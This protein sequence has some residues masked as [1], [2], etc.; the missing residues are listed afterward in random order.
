MKIKLVE[1]HTTAA[2]TV[3]TES[4]TGIAWS[5]SD[6]GQISE[7]LF[8]CGE[9]GKIRKW[10][11]CGGPVSLVSELDSPCTCL[12][13]VPPIQAQSDTMAVGCADGSIRFFN[14][15]GRL[16][17]KF[18]AHEGALISVQWSHDATT[19][20]STGE[21]CFLKTWSRSGMQRSTLIQMPREINCFTWSPDCQ[22]VL[23]GS[24]SKIMLKP[25]QA[26]QKQF[27]WKA[28][29]GCVL[30]LDWCS[31]GDLIV[32]GGEDCRYKL[33]GSDGRLL[34]ASP[35]LDNVVT[36]VAWSPTGRCFAVGSFNIIKLC[37]KHGWVI[38][39]V[40]FEQMGSVLVFSWTLDSTLLAVGGASG[41]VQVCQT[42]NRTVVW[43][44]ITAFLDDNNIILVKDELNTTTEELDF[45]DR[46]V[47]FA[48]GF[49]H[50]VV[51][52]VGQVHIYHSANWNSPHVEDLNE[53]VLTICLSSSCFAI[54]ERQAVQIWL[55]EG[56]KLSAVK[57]PGMKTEILTN[58]T[59]SLSRDTICIARSN[60]MRFFDVH[61]ARPIG[62]PIDHR[63]DVQQV[64]LSQY[65]SGSDRKVA[66][67]DRCKDL[68]ISS[69]HNVS[70]VK[71]A[72][73]IDSVQWH[74]DVTDMLAAVGDRQLYCWLYP[75]A[76]FLDNRLM[77]AALIKRDINDIAGV[78]AALVSFYGSQVTLRRKDGAQIVMQL[79]P[80]APLL[81]QQIGNG[82]WEKAARLC[83]CAKS[84]PLWAA[85][86]TM[87]LQGRQLQA[88][89]EALAAI[90]EKTG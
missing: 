31:L 6:G 43:K 36:S 37:D 74:Q 46:V 85:F 89:E 50:L 39:S 53:Q 1:S 7:D 55:Y 17:K 67:L 77:E 32:S 21:D 61:S 47:D 3:H 27:E 62:S 44:H 19:L 76:I 69:V 4:C 26:G 11:E 59:L 73:M 29:E 64:S 54:V 18:A 38:N 57:Y 60:Q 15:S 83:R 79:S 35:A 10:D 12:D 88:A 84:D 63:V 28:H 24:E 51:I 56:K 70:L 87:A 5:K 75:S 34:L 78:E 8:S 41:A 16:E 72:S 52:T 45:K 13:F 9:D 22:T 40:I 90:D 81:Y 23:F 30:A 42:V 33:W 80:F 2:K 86:A 58:A 25:I 48:L 66:M 14:R 68:Y 65:G 82:A 49:D 71:I 20:V